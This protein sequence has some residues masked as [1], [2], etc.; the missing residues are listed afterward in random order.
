MYF[1]FEENSGGYLVKIG[2]TEQRTD[3]VTDKV[4]DNQALIID[5]IRKNQYITTMEL[6]EIVGISQRK[7]KENIA[8]LKDMKIIKRL[9]NAKTGHWQI[10]E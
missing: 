1:N 3:K 7:I 6:A 5:A 4:A 8:K 9:G 2:Y 10:L